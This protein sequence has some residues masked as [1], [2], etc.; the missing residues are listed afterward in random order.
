MGRTVKALMVVLL[1]ATPASAACRWTWDCGNGPCKQVQ[2][3]DNAFDIPAIRPPE[4]APIPAPTIRPLSPPVLP[5][6][7]A[8]QCSPQYLCNTYGQCGWQT[9]C[10]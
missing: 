5:P 10:R 3:C 1:T 6:I 9:V 4:I 7:G 2:I 8:K